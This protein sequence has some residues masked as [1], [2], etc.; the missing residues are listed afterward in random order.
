MGFAEVNGLPDGFSLGCHWGEAPKAS[1]S[2]HAQGGEKLL[3]SS[4]IF[5]SATLLPLH[6]SLASFLELDSNWRQ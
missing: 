4:F 5:F 6:F 3:G 2:M 1:P